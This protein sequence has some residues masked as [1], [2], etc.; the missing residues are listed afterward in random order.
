MIA[1]GGEN[2]PHTIMNESEKKC[3]FLGPSDVIEVSNINKTT[4]R[5]NHNAI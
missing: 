1:S 3:H 5:G 2:D 4:P